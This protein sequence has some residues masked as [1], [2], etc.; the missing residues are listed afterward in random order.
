MGSVLKHG[1]D[2]DTHPRETWGGAGGQAVLG[3]PLALHGEQGPGDPG[4][5]QGV[6]V[7]SGSGFGEHPSALCLSRPSFLDERAAGDASAGPAHGRAPEFP[8]C[9]QVLSDAAC[10]C[11]GPSLCRKWVSV[12]TITT[13]VNPPCAVGAD[14]QE[15]SGLMRKLSDFPDDRTEEAEAAHRAP[16]APSAHE[17]QPPAAGVSAR[18]RRLPDRGRGGGASPLAPRSSSGCAAGGCKYSVYTGCT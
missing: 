4:A 1:A 8:S 17:R 11:E 9:R 16:G 12:Q 6:W 3:L 10:V 14:A 5:P 18:R 15:A 7:P 13:E 2:Q